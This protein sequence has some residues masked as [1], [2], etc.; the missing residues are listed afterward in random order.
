MPYFSCLHHR[1][2]PAPS[3]CGYTVRPLAPLS[4][5]DESYKS[6]TSFLRNSTSVRVYM[7]RSPM[8]ASKNTLIRWHLLPP[9]SA[10]H[11]S[12]HTS[13][14]GWLSSTVLTLLPLNG[15]HMEVIYR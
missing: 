8:G 13:E 12:V 15:N 10:S 11:E 4:R 1:P 7:V 3:S 14:H 9:I 2:H 6:Y 5:A